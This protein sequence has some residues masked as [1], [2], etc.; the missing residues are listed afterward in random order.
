[1]VTRPRPVRKLYGQ[2]DI[3]LSRYY[4]LYLAQLGWILLG[5][6]LLTKAYWPSDCTP[7]GL[8]DVFRCSVELP[9]SRGWVEA[10]LLTWLWSTPIL[11]AL[12]ASRWFARLQGRQ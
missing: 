11:L 4:A 9:V 3:G 5:A 1:M 7:H 2:A 12:E 6:F 8:V 10:A